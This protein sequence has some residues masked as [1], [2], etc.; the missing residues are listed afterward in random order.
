MPVF[1]IICLANSLKHG[2]RC[3]AGFK[4]DES[5]WLRPVSGKFDGR[6]YP[7]HYTLANGQE[8]VLFNILRIGCTHPR[9]EAHQ[10][11]NWAISERQW[12]FIGNCTTTLTDF[13]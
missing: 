5:G 4:T 10:P 6:L 7:E 3:L 2:G 8:A 12:Q 11:E 1:E 9:P 13:C